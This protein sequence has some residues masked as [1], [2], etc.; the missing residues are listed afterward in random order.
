ML[1]TETAQYVLL[2][3]ENVMTKNTQNAGAITPAMIEAFLSAKA[4]EEKAAKEAAKE[5][6]AKAKTDGSNDRRNSADV[7]KE[8]SGRALHYCTVIGGRKFEEG[9]TVECHWVGRNK[10][11][12]DTARIFDKSG[13]P[14]MVD[15]KDKGWIDPKFLKGGKELPKER[16]AAIEALRGTESDE[17]ILVP[18]SIGVEKDKSVLVNYTGWFSGSWFPKTMITK[19]GETAEGLG[20]YEVPAWKVR[21]EKGGDA[22]EMLKTKQA[23]LQEMVDGK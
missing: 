22:F 20:I 10:F 4:A 15:G 8:F 12:Q 9:T 18:A 16:V 3:K 14:I 7:A 21:K 11:R 5:A 2:K 23:A 19:V 17:T 6:K 1:L 13:N